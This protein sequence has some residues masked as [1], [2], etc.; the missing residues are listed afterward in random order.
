MMQEM[1]ALIKQRRVNIGMIYLFD[2]CILQ[3]SHHPEH[4]VRLLVFICLIT[5][6]L[7]QI[8]LS[9]IF[10]PNNIHFEEVGAGV[11]N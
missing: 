9:P 11:I 7:Y 6:L 3:L 4:L 1:S 2:F 8:L 5:F 10:S